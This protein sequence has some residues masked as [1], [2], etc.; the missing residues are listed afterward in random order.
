M[1]RQQARI[2]SK[3]AMIVDVAM[4]VAAF[5]L[6]YGIARNF[7]YLLDTGYYNWILFVEIP[8]WL[9]WLYHFNLYASLRLSGTLKIIAS[10]FKAFLCSAV[11]T[12]SLI[13]LVEPHGFSRIFF[14]VSTITSF[15]LISVVKLGIK[16]VLS[17]IRKK[18]RNVRYLLV[19]GMGERAEQMI[20]LIKQHSCWGLHIVGFVCDSDFCDRIFHG[21]PMVGHLEDIV[22]FCRKNPV[23]EVIWCSSRNG[24]E[25]EG[26]FHDLSA[27]GI[28][29]RTML[30]CYDFPVIR[31]EL[32]L[33]HDRIPLI[34]YY[35][36]E[37]DANQLLAKRCLDLVGSLVGLVIL[38]LLLPG[39]ALV[40]R[41]DSPGPIFFGQMRVGR[42]GRPFRC[43]K[44]RSMYQDAE[45]RKQQL[46][47]QNEMK[48]AMFKMADDPR[49]TRVGRFI[50]KTSLD[51]LPQFWNV[52]RGEM[53][54]VGTRPPTPDE[55][56]TYENWHHKRICIK[57]GITGLWQVSG[58]NKI[59]DFD[60][61][62][63]LD[64]QYI[65]S[66][67]I[68]LDIRILFKTVWVVLARKGSC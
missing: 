64:I 19:V 38:A 20:E 12:A 23:D 39:I 6:S 27:M 48:G 11:M 67:S 53:S 65:E 16:L 60:Q 17:N 26:L 56:T 55:V 45:A 4:I 58:R 5:Y 54:L 51:E 18:G 49:V 14:A 68:W 32:S 59:Q 44:F 3:I 34:T 25:K 30:E 13:Y 9:F 28:T 33:F 10:I 57:P 36:K 24:W 1:L 63:R 66:W 41:L 7:T 61:V 40:I 8:I 35:A 42:N 2:F 46:M 29:F 52:L 43:W 22:P 47:E 15:A 37:F 21:V 50:R 31:T 62:A